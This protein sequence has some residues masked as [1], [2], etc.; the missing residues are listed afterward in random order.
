MYTLHQTKHKLLKIWQPK[1]GI[2]NVSMVGFVCVIKVAK[3]LDAKRS[4]AVGIFISSLHLQPA[5]IEIG[6]HRCLFCVDW[7]SEM[8]VVLCGVINL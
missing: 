7:S 2:S 5:E 1:H 8:E 6:R 4:Q 3:L